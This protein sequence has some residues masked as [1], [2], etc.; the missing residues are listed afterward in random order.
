MVIPAHAPASA[1]SF[2]D[3]SDTPPQYEGAIERRRGEEFAAAAAAGEDDSDE[4]EE[5]S[6][7]GSTANKAGQKPGV[8]K[9]LKGKETFKKKMSNRAELARAVERNGGGAKRG[10]IEG[11]LSDGSEDS[12]DSNEEDRGAAQQHSPRRG[13][14]SVGSTLLIP[15]VAPTSADG[16]RTWRRFNTPSTCTPTQAASLTPHLRRTATLHPNSSSPA[17]RDTIHPVS[18]A[19]RG[20]TGCSS[21]R[22]TRTR[23]RIRPLL[24]WRHRMPGHRITHHQSRP[25][26]PCSLTRL[27]PRLLSSSLSSHSQRRSSNGT[28]TSSLGTPSSSCSRTISVNKELCSRCSDSSSP[29]WGCRSTTSRCWTTSLG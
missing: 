14:P 9:S 26:G 25:W 5:T 15:V 12:P 3:G 22:P 29:S 1:H 13:E 17:R 16:P 10:F 21:P 4:D 11:I 6:R 24:T 2:A 8:V 19:T 20:T 28:R 27:T 7:R 18:P 23:T